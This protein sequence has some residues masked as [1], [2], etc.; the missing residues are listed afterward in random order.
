MA[1]TITF[2]LRSPSSSTTNANDK[3]GD[4]KKYPL[5]I[6]NAQTKACS[7]HKIAHAKRLEKYCTDEHLK[8]HGYGVLRVTLLFR[9]ESNIR[10]KSKSRANESLLRKGFSR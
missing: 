4:R 5:S 6:R 9:S 2:F 1:V 7:P 3:M 10:I 8:C